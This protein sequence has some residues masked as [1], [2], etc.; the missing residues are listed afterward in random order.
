MSFQEQLVNEIN[1][2]RTNPKAYAKK[3]GKYIDYFKGKALY[4]PGA[5]A[6]I[7]TEE[8]AEAYKEAVDFL[9][10]AEP[11]EPLKP[12]KGL[13]RIAKDFLEEVQ[14]VDPQD[15]G[16]INLEEII[17]KYGAYN[18]HINREVSMGDETPEN[19]LA[20]LLASDGDPSRGHRE[21]LLSTDLQRIGAAN[22]T[23]KIYRFCTVIIYCTQFKNKVDSNDDGYFDGSAPTE[24]KKEEKGQ[25]LKPKK[26]VMIHPPKEEPK[27][28]GDDNDDEVVSVKRKEKIVEVNGKKKKEIKIIKVL[29]DGSKEVDTVYQDYVEG[30]DDDD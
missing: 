12:S 28:E 6:G 23:H 27:Q 30:E 22:G 15:L 4:I 26:V 24:T 25:T 21:A 2:L 18:G 9:S 10:K 3:V 17:D 20:S 5:K 8:G 16:N 11:V 7:R 19:I 29:K 1:E 14:K 13:G